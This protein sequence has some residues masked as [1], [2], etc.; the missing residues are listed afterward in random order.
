MGL[1]QTQADS[2]AISR[3]DSATPSVR[4]DNAT[5]EASQRQASSL[6]PAGRNNGGDDA[7]FRATNAQSQPHAQAGMTDHAQ[8]APTS[9]PQQSRESSFMDESLPAAATS[10]RAET[11]RSSLDAS[12]LAT[13]DY[14]MAE[15]DDE[16]APAPV[17]EAQL[18]EE[19]NLE[20][21]VRR[22]RRPQQCRRRRA[23]T[24]VRLAKY[25]FA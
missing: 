4:N 9:P 2:E 7:A 21:D 10:G 12:S 14:A 5:V 6:E 8:S 3:R 19:Q 24:C 25:V 23:S 16:S 20:A 22:I 17:Q 13:T 1:N 18:A 15:Q 11:G